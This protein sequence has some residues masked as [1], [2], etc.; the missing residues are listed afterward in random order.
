[1]GFSCPRYSI[2]CICL[3]LQ[4]RVLGRLVNTTIDD[5]SLS[6]FY[7]P[8][9]AW[10]DSKNPCQKCTAHPNASM[11][12]N[13]TWHDST[14]DQDAQ[15]SP[16][17]VRNVSTIFNGTAIYVSCILAKTTF[18]PSGDSDMSFYIDDVLVGQFSYI[19]PGESGFDYNVTVYANS[20]IPAGMHRFTV[21]NGHIG[22][23]KSLLLFDAFIYSYDDGQSDHDNSGITATMSVG[24]II[25][26]VVAFLV[27]GI[28]GTIIFLLYRRRRLI[29]KLG[30]RRPIVE[31]YRDRR[32]R[33]PPSTIP[34]FT[35]TWAFP[36][37]HHAPPST[38][39]MSSFVANDNPSLRQD[40]KRPIS[41]TRRDQLVNTTPRSYH[42]REPEPSFD[43]EDHD[44]WSSDRTRS[45]A[46]V[47]SIH[48]ESI[49]R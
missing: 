35:T 49:K 9:D 4:L 30:N 2:I 37:H 29:L 31:A 28:L 23:R 24:T 26:V 17:Q 36:S 40:D 20:S 48:H 39:S 12:I 5:Q 1:M 44:I 6:L 25:G 33:A 7:S 11:A 13:S 14:F 47:R 38:T 41:D 22:G 42:A 43:E 27:T 18:S 45:E 19:A 34:P 10:N 32:P 3:L 15:I 8:E 46:S 16:N 21:Q